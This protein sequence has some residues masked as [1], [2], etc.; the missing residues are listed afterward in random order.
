MFELQT[1][2]VGSQ[3]QVGA[4]QMLAACPEGTEFFL[5]PEPE[6]K[7]DANAIAVYL[8]HE[9]DG[10]PM[11]LERAYALVEAG[12]NDVLATKVGYIPKSD[13]SELA[14]LVGQ[15]TGF[16]RRLKVTLMFA[17]MDLILVRE[18]TPDGGK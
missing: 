18:E 2:I 1:R 9:E 11:P 7:Y 3:F 16:L 5:E 10:T 8:P 12:S 17:N 4:R 6:N 15:E 13:N 14:Q